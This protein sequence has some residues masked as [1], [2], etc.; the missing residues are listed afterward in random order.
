MDDDRKRSIGKH[1]Q[2]GH[3]SLDGFH[4]Q[5]IALGDEA[6]LAKLPRRI[7]EHGNHCARG[8]QQRPLLATARGKTKRWRRL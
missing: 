4:R 6:V 1:R 8:G 3:I 2:I 5:T 7:I